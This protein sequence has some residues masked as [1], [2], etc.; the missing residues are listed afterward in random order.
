MR[1]WA[2][3]FRRPS[4]LGCSD[5]SRLRPSADYRTVEHFFDGEHIGETDRLFA[6]GGLSELRRARK[7]SMPETVKRIAELVAA[8]PDESWV[9]WC[10]LNAEAEALAKAIPGGVNLHGSLSESEKEKKLECFQAETYWCLITKPGIAGH[11]MNWQH[12]A[13]M[14]WCG[15]G[16]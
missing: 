2:S 6:H 9:I 13:R 8:E 14:A 10:E 16:Y 12:C 5:P 3:I 7:L 4:D 1:T 15:M 11:G